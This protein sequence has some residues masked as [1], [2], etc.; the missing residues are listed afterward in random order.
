MAPQPPAATA[1]PLAAVET[2]ATRW[3]PVYAFRNDQ[4]V[5]EALRLYGE[6]AGEEIDLYGRLLGADGTFVDVGCNIWVI[7]RALG[8]AAPGR[9]ILGLEPQPVSFRLAAANTLLQPGVT[10]YQLAASDR[11]GVV[12]IDEIDLSRVANYGGFS[13]DEGRAWP[14]R[15][16]CP[17]VRLDTFVPPR[18]PAPRLVKIDTE[19]M[20]AAVLRGMSGL[21]HDRLTISAEADRR[22]LAPAILAEFQALG[23]RCHVGFFRVIS[24]SNPR[25][26]PDAK[27]CRR[28]HVHI[29]GFAGDPPEWIGRVRDVW[30]IRDAAEFDAAW[31]KYFGDVDAP[32]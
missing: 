22:A 11:D 14:R 24:G 28:R 2:V 6:Y 21:V 19:G 31:V 4:G 3:G 7:A 20:E 27:H 1:A 5:S 32:V 12:P 18:A 26:D 29:L 13:I 30:P 17:T 15:V 23:C 10:V 8:V 16:P 25:F 9:T